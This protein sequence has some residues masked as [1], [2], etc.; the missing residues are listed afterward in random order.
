[1][2]PVFYAVGRFKCVL[3]GTHIFFYPG[4]LQNALM[5]LYPFHGY[6][7]NWLS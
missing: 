2:L 1:M 4:Y 3:Y 7:G 5:Y 6:F